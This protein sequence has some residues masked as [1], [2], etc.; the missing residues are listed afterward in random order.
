MHTTEQRFPKQTTEYK[1]LL[2]HKY[3]VHLEKN[4]DYSPANI[5]VAGELGILVRM[6]DKF[7]RICNLYGIPFP[8][9]GPQ[10]DN[11]SEEIMQLIKDHPNSEKV[12]N[13]LT[14]LSHSCE[15]DWSKFKEGTP[16]NESLDDSWV[17]LSVYTDIGILKRRKCWGR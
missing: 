14:N 4:K 15:F 6:W 16:S 12:K 5:L 7:C 2:E 17:D 1:K 11:A 13:I 9:L 3:K 8:T 10:V